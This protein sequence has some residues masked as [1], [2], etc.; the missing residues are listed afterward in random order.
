[1]CFHDLIFLY[2]QTGSLNDMTDEGL[3]TL[4]G[5]TSSTNFQLGLYFNWS[6]LISVNVASCG[7]FVIL[8]VALAKDTGIM[9]F[10]SIIMDELGRV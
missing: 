10:M 8:K 6:V 1:M 5:I 9:D 2:G 4:R 3:K 7:S